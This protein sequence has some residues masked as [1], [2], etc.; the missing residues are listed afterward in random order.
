MWRRHRAARGTAVRGDHL[1]AAPSPIPTSPIDHY[2][3]IGDDRLMW[4]RTAHAPRRPIRGVRRKRQADILKVY[5]QLGEVEIE[6]AWSG[7]IGYALHRM[8]QIGEL[9]PGLWIAS[10][11]GG[12][13]LNTT[14]MAG[15][16]IAQRSSTATTAGGCS[17]H[18]SWSGPAGGSAAR[19]C[20][21]TTG[22][23]MPAS[24]AARQ[25]RQRE[26]E[27]RRARQR[28]ALRAPEERAEAEIGAAVPADRSCPP[29]PGWSTCRLIRSAPMSRSRWRRRG[30]VAA[31]VS[32][33]PGGGGERRAA[34]SPTADELAADD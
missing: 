11:F 6:Y 10:G 7:M 28:A 2:R 8:P 23:S 16:I 4:R 20:R 12:H 14:A 9:S 22:G 5:P 13:G 27:V 1:S 3:I 19:P 24:A 33:C 17:R 34:L 29:S 15:R 18:T 26:E 30:G 32:R 31:K 25:A 21:A